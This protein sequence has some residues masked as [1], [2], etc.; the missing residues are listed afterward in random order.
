M[1]RRPVV[2]DRHES[3]TYIPSLDLETSLHRVT[4]P[5]SSESRPNPF[6]P[7]NKITSSLQI[8]LTTSTIRPF[9]VPGPVVASR[10][11]GSL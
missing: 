5:L 1:G 7:I 3:E 8:S 4:D 11:I 6:N 2:P 10:T 9:L